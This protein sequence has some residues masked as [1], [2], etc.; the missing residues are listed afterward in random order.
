MSQA[1][2]LHF[3]LPKFNNP[4][5]LKQAFIHRSA[6]NEQKEF[7]AS[8]E[9]LEYLGDAVLELIVSEYLYIKYPTLP[10]G[11]LTSLRSK[12]VQTSTLAWA[13]TNLCLPA[14]IQLSKGEKLSGGDLKPTILANTLEAVIG[15]LYLDSGY[16]VTKKFI[17]QVLIKPFFE[18]LKSVLPQDY[19]SHLQE[20]IQSQKL[21]TPIYQ[22]LDQT[23][24]DHNKTFS[25]AV[26]TNN[27]AL[28]QG[29][30]KSKQKAEQDAAKKALEKIQKKD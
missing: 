28:A 22:V 18:N 9:R 11:K 19:K 17:T 13:A 16:I 5:L 12:I 3:L 25:V 15:A 14:K 30:G 7:T 20:V 27:Q 4:N 23:G 29:F 2:T 10:E 6:L 8:N 1:A 21:P 26:T 24:P